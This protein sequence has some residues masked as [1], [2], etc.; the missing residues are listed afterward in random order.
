MSLSLE[1]REL[2]EGFGQGSEIVRHTWEEQPESAL[3]RMDER[4][5]W[6]SQEGWLRG[7]G[8]AGHGAIRL[9]C[10]HFSM[11]KLYLSLKKCEPK[12]ITVIHMMSRGL[13]KGF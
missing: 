9:K 1:Q 3:W 13:R 12:T 7:W 10:V 5:V 4:R 6:E 11:Y 8:R 2:L